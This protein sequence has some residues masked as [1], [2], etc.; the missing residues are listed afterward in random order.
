MCS[1]EGV[2]NVLRRA[3][4]NR[5]QTLED[6]RKRKILVDSS[7]ISIEEALTKDISSL[8]ELEDGPNEDSEAR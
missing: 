7:I 4:E 3:I 5:T 2:V 6:L 1:K 8:E